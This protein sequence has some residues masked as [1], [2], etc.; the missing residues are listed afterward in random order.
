MIKENPR[1]LIIVPVD[2]DTAECGLIGTREDRLKDLD[3]SFPVIVATFNEAYK[4]QFGNGHML[5]DG[6]HRYKRAARE[7]IEHVPGVRLTEEETF[8]V[9]RWRSGQPAWAKKERKERD[10]ANRAARRQRSRKAHDK[11]KRSGTT[12]AEESG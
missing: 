3:M 6:W 11:G 8:K 2:K 9:M 12:G 1:P 7:G 10:A 5:I 4:R